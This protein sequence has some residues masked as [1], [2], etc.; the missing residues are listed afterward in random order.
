MKL[1]DFDKNVYASTALQENYKMN[2]D[3]A[4]MDLAATK[5][6]LKKVRSLAL[7]AKQ[8]TDFY[9]NAPNSSYMK[10]VFMEEALVNH[11]NN[12]NSQPKTRI[13]LENEKIEESQVYLA[14]QDMVDTVSKMLEQIGEMQVKELP[15]LVDSI[16]SEIGVNES[17]SFQTQ[18]ASQL[19]T[20]N[21]ALKEVQAGLK[22][23]VGQLTGVSA[24]FETEPSPAGNEMPAPSAE[25]PGMDLE[26]PS[27]EEMPAEEPEEEPTSGIGREKR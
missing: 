23:A 7:E 24:G 5:N 2:F 25:L 15:A 3:V 1:T 26:E 6:M 13:V 12:L 9:K 19:D 16:E 20:L 21:A 27:A 8:A 22:S 17:Q 10:L 4:K 14:A 11:F 18:V